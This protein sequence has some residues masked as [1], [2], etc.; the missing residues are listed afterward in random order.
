MKPTRANNETHL[1]EDSKLYLSTRS[2]GTFP[3]WNQHSLNSSAVGAISC[4]QFTCGAQGTS[5]HSTLKTASTTSWDLWIQCT[6][7]QFNRKL[8][9]M[10]VQGIITACYKWNFKRKIETTLIS[11]KKKLVNCCRFT[12]VSQHTIQLIKYKHQFSNQH[13]LII[14]I[15]ILGTAKKPKNHKSFFHLFPF[16]CSLW[17]LRLVGNQPI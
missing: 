12:D 6:V 8:Y 7:S 11:W 13:S 9:K 15:R 1:K 16:L 17:P 10:Y 14:W 2:G 4:V 5:F 3:S